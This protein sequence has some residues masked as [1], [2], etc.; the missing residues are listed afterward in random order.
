MFSATANF[1]FWPVPSRQSTKVGE[2]CIKEKIE[3]SP[4]LPSIKFLSFAWT[5]LYELCSLNAI[6]FLSFVSTSEV[7]RVDSPLE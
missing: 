3:T 6:A 7:K 5:Q 4:Y 2:I 1:L